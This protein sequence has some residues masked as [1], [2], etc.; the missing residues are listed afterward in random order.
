MNYYIMT[1]INIQCLTDRS[2]FINFFSEPITIPKNTQI[3]LTKAHFKIAVN[4][5]TEIFVPRNVAIADVAFRIE[6]DGISEDITWGDLYDAHTDLPGI[7]FFNSFD[8]WRDDYT[9]LPNNQFIF[10]NDNTNQAETKTPFNTILA[11]AITKKFNFYSVTPSPV[12][13]NFVDDVV[14]ILRNVGGTF[15]TQERGAATTYRFLNA[16]NNT[17]TDL[18]FTIE[19]SPIKMLSSNQ[20][21]VNVNNDVLI[22]WVQGGALHSLRG[23]TGACCTYLNQVNFDYNGGYIHTFPNLT[24]ANA[25][26]LISFGLNFVGRGRQAAD[27][28]HAFNSGYDTTMYDIGVEFGY[29]GANFVYNII[30]KANQYNSTTDTPILHSGHLPHRKVNGFNNNGDHFFIQVQRSNDFHDSKAWTVNILH[31]VNLD[32]ET[33]PNATIVYSEDFKLNPQTDLVPL[34]QANAAAGTDGWEFNNNAFIPQSD[35]THEQGDIMLAGGSHNLGS[36]IIEP[37]IEQGTANETESCW[38]FWNSW[39]L[40]NVNTAELDDLGGRNNTYTDVSGNNYLRQW[41][42]P[43][44]IK[45][46]DNLYVRRGY[47]IGNKEL[48]TLFEYSNN[49]IGEYYGIRDVDWVEYLPQLVNVS[50]NNIDVKNFNGILPYG[51]LSTTGIAQDQSS[52]DARVVGTVSFPA[53]QVQDTSINVEIDYEPFNLLYRP[54]NNPNI[55]TINQLNIEIFYKDFVNNRKRNIDDILG[56]ANLEFHMRSGG[57]PAPPNKAGLRPY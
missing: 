54:I 16:S 22:N 36:I 53:D 39:G 37:K 47:V 21:F 19:Y 55:Q 20:T 45:Y 12:Y 43:V 1:S 23:A 3:A 7:E 38:S 49:T 41:K 26:G 11:R 29:D 28:L 10:Y 15:I 31:G 2:N 24:T 25:G 51:A 30:T 52:G 14:D 50:V 4:V 5:A 57:T 13:K 18:G 33:D 56:T 42:N 48:N 35:Q 46:S 32:P 6:I 44:N 8:D 34:Y 17:L 9:Y 40:Y 27:I